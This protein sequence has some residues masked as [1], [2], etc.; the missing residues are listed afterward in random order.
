MAKYILRYIFNKILQM[1]DS[2]LKNSGITAHQ[3][4]DVHIRKAKVLNNR[5][6]LLNKLPKNGVIAELGV[7]IG[8]FSQ[9]IYNTCCPK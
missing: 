3:L 4:E 7:N 6:S 2:R 5:D 1:R 9:K 8:D